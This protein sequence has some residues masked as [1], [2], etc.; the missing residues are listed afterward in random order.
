[1]KQWNFKITQNKAPE[2]CEICHQTDMFD[3][4]TNLCIRC[5]ALP[6]EQLT[7]PIFIISPS[8]SATSIAAVIATICFIVG[9]ID[10][11]TLST[12]RLSMLMY[13][14][15][16]FYIKIFIINLINLVFSLALF[17]WCKDKHNDRLTYQ[18]VVWG[19]IASVIGM[20]GSGAG[21]IIPLPGLFVRF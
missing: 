11:N 14:P 17:N 1:M 12:S 6:I 3:R 2:R 4:Q 21:L 16:S 15:T 7:N 9:V 10:I 5:S 18:V 20:I 13:S 8:T 19:R